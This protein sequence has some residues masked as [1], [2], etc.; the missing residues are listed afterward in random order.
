MTVNVACLKTPPARYAR[1]VLLR[2]EIWTKCKGKIGLRYVCGDGFFFRSSYR[3]EYYWYNVLITF[4]IPANQKYSGK[5][6]VSRDALFVRS[7]S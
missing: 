3:T 6:L 1:E 7:I 2:P 4:E 5:L